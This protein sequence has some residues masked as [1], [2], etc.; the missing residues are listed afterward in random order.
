MINYKELQY[1]FEYGFCSSDSSFSD[2][3]KGNS[4]SR[5]QNSKT[6]NSNLRDQKLAKFA[7]KI[8]KANGLN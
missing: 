8:L 7:F 1:G 5:S 2:E 4:H 3:K 6:T